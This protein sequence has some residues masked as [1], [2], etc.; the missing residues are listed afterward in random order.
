MNKQSETYVRL[1]IPPDDIE[2]YDVKEGL[3]IEI[4]EIQEDK[5]EINEQM[6]ASLEGFAEDYFSEEYWA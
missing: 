2:Y 3:K 5:E 6:Q 4:L 1:N